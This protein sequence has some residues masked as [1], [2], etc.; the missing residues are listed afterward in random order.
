MIQRRWDFQRQISFVSCVI[1]VA[2]SSVLFDGNWLGASLHLQGWERRQRVTA[3]IGS[4]KKARVRRCSPEQEL[5]S[6]ATQ[7]AALVD[8][9]RTRQRPLFD[10][11]NGC[12]SGG[13]ECRRTLYSEVEC[14]AD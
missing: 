6:E 11:A 7:D 13:V 4:G 9:E 14:L 3:W 12:L 1:D 10:Q 8:D 5:C 2:G